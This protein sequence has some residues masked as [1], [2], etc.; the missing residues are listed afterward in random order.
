MG[1]R[2]LTFVYSVR[3]EPIINLYCQ[4]D[5]YPDGYGLDLAEFLNSI[6]LV[7]GLVTGLSN[8]GLANGTGCLAAQLVAKFKVG[9]G[10]YYLFPVTDNDCGQEWEYHIYSDSVEVRN[11]VGETVFNDNWVE[12]A[13]YCKPA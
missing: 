9:A 8:D 6:K 3:G 13:E 12:F 11:S 1:T 7:N 2:A 10:S 5:G 4:Y